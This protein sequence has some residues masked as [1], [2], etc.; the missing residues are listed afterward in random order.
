MLET[1]NE[2]E[3]HLD[4]HWQPSLVLAISNATEYEGG[5]FHSP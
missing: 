3:T 2:A 5:L 4:I 1:Q